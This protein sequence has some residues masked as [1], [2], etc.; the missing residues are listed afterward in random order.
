MPSFAYMRFER[1]AGGGGTAE[2]VD[3]IKVSNLLEA[4]E[5]PRFS[6][7]WMQENVFN[8]AINAGP[9]GI[10]NTAAD[11]VHLPTLHLKTDKAEAYSAEWFAQSLSGGVGA[12]LPFMLMTGASGMAMRAADRQLAGTAA[13][14]VLNPYLSS[15]TLATIAGGS[16]YGFLQKPDAEHS[17]FGNAVGMGVGLALFSKGNDMVKEL[18]MLQKAISYPLIG[19]VGGGAMTEVSQ[20]ASNLK[21][22]S[23]DALLQGAV[24]G[25]S[26][27]LV[28]GL[29][30]DYLN[31]KY[32][33]SRQSGLERRADSQA[34][35]G[36]E[37]NEL[38]LDGKQI[39][40]EDLS[41]GSKES[42]AEIRRL[43]NE[44]SD[45]VRQ[46]APRYPHP[47]Q[48]ESLSPEEIVK[49]GFYHPDAENAEILKTFSDKKPAPLPDAKVV[50]AEVGKVLKDMPLARTTGDLKIGEWN[51]EF[52]TGD[53]AKYFRDTYKQIIPRHHLLFV[54]EA[55]TEGLRQIAQDTGYNFLVSRENSRGQAV[56]F[57]INPRL[58]IDGSQS[59]DSV[60]QVG[61]IPDLRPALKVDLTDSSTG[62]NLSAVVVHLKSMRGG[63][64]HTAPIRTAQAQTLADSLGPNFK[65]IIAGDWN[66]FLDKTQDLNPLKNAG[67]KIANAG[68]SRTTQAM[69]GRLDGFMYKGLNGSLG[70]ENINPFFKNPLITRGLS[71]H[72]LLTTT[73]ESG[74]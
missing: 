27:N 6:S 50:A 34:K 62:E 16:A 7:H 74:K 26:L 32:Q 21:P 11:L 72:A 66:T 40:A 41:P 61:N 23:R 10:Y 29:G 30:G 64:T 9:L 24:Q 25:A 2:M 35:P 13:G 38:S 33:E 37:T 4:P 14:A 15:K 71:D 56:G 31:K 20:L 48:F 59:I 22:A 67:F 5:S 47:D 54:E 12:A 53:K 17:R 55:N 68:D 1:R 49:R 39:K 58:K 60:A 18:P 57:L 44:Y 65:G 70:P 46:N 3:S 28:M 19:L 69:G 42:F 8:P 73:L 52:L 63:E 36:A 43:Q 51:M 45:Y